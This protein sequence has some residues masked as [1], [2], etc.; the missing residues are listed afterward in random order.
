MTQSND[1]TVKTSD[2]AESAND[3]TLDPTVFAPFPEDELFRLAK[4]LRD[5]DQDHRMSAL[6]EDEVGDAVALAAGDAR[7]AVRAL[8]SV[9]GKVEAPAEPDLPRKAA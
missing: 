8:V 1:P 4:I 5:A 3:L 7:A 9:W 6:R 2:N